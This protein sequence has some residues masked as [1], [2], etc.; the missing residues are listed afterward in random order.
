MAE[1]G[2]VVVVEVG[3]GG[4]GG[5][6]GKGGPCWASRILLT[7][8]SHATGRQLCARP[9]GGLDAHEPKTMRSPQKDRRHTTVTLTLSRGEHQDTSPNNSGLSN[10]ESS[11]DHYLRERHH[12]LLSSLFSTTELPPFFATKYNKSTKPLCL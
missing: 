10:S 5:G 1:V 4:G 12:F 8:Q 6:G 9:G 7:V 11:S 2:E 3:T